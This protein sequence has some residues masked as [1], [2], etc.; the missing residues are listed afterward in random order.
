MLGEPVKIAL[1]YL[2]IRNLVKINISNNKNSKTMK[3]RIFIRNSAL[4]A[5]ALTIPAIRSFGNNFSSRLQHS[6]KSTGEN[7]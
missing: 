3:R 4:G 6:E 1:I 2:L 5:M 7:W